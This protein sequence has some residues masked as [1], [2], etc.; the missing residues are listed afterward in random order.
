[1]NTS[2]PP[3]TPIP[4]QPMGKV[5]FGQ[6]FLAFLRLGATAFGG[7]AMVA[8]IGDL[9]VKKR[10]WLSK[11]SFERGVALCQSIPGATAMQTAAY[12][13]LRAGGPLGALAAFVGFGLPAFMLMILLSAAYQAGRDLALVLAVFHG[14]HAIVIAI[15]TNAIINFGRTSVRGWRDALI[16][17]GAVALLVFHV[18]PILVIV[19]AAGIAVLLYWRVAPAETPPLSASRALAP[20]LLHWPFLIVLFVATGL[21]A[22][23]VLD[24]QLLGLAAVMLKVDVFAFGGGFASVPLMLHEVVDVRNWLDSRTFMDGIALGQVTPGPIVITATFVGYQVAGILGA[25]VGT[26]AV[27]SPSFF[28]VLLTVPYFDRLQKSVF[29]GRILRGILA[30]FVG[31]L[32]AVAIQF[33]LAVSWNV[34]VIIIAVVALVALRL[35]VDILWV[36]LVGALTSVLVL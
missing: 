26:L 27:F 2:E 34:A 7:P 23:Y 6:L 1:M 17:I 36:V 29:F 24:K 20:R 4:L 3:S 21:A 28:M 9:A 25:I 32:L 22:L 19:G 13:G 14:L 30:S 10:G 35:K 11:E 5:P 8:Y 33:G 18:N 15:I 12:V 31:L 16:A